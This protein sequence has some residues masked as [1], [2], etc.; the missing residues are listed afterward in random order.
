MQ[1][2]SSANFHHFPIKSFTREKIPGFSALQ[3]MES[4]VGPG[5][6]ASVVQFSSILSEIKYNLQSADN[7]AGLPI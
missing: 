4:W 1:A 3:A 6:K 5:K 7:H 2:V